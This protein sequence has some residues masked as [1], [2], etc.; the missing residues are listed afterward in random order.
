MEFRAQ[1]SGKAFVDYSPAEEAF[2]ATGA[3]IRFGGGRA[4]YN[5]AEDFIQ[6]PPK[7]AFVSQHEYY[8]TLAHEGCHWT[9]HSSRLDRLNTNARFGDAAY[10]FEELCAEIGGDFL[11][12][13]L[14]IP[15]SD[16]LSNHNAY[17]QT[18][19]NVLQQD[20]GAIIRASSQ[21]SKAADFILAFSRKDEEATEGEEAVVAGAAE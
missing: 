3:D 12:S 19:L 9:G 16:D 5:P 4:F 10:S 11:C 1:R 17:L 14:A 6:L 8:A 2:T 7:E 18:W 20:H 21:A 15:Q 13:E